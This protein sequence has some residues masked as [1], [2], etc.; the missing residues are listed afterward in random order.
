MGGDGGS[1]PKRI[2][3]V[4][5]K[6]KPET[7]DRDAANMA[8]WRHCT[9]KH[10]PLKQPIVVDCNGL[11]YNKDA[12]LEYLLDRQSFE[13]GPSYIKKLK[14]VKELKLTENSS[15]KSNHNEFGNEYLDVYTSP[16]ICP[17][18]FVEMNGKYKFCAIWTCG[19]VL[20]DRALRSVNKSTNGEEKLVCPRCDKEYSSS[21]D[22]IILNPEDEDIVFMDQRRERLNANQKKNGSTKRKLIEA[23]EQSN[24]KKSKV[25]STK[26]TNGASASSSSST[27]PKATTSK[28]ASGSKVTNTK[29]TIQQ[30]PTKSDLYKSLFTTSDAAKKKEKNK[31]HW[32]T[33]N[34]LYY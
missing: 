21:D 2:E 11:L 25:E 1:I 26:S 15:F 9:L 28:I 22:V 12:I 32:V 18:T 27:I 3:L 17:I 14:D 30:D 23:D 8:K 20:S 7:K 29:S 4:Q 13:H 19:C 10:G 31:A 5:Q 16:F 34:P 24:E 33:Y 6:K